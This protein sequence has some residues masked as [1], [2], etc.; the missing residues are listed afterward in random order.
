MNFLSLLTI[1]G[2]M[3]CWTVYAPIVIISSALAGEV[4]STCGQAMSTRRS[5]KCGNC[6]MPSRKNRNG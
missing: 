2:I 6:V 5:K 1:A 4:K 3:C